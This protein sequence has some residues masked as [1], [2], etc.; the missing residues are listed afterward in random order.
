MPF[1]LTG[2]TATISLQYGSAVFGPVTVSLE[3]DRLI[4]PT[5]IV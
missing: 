3:F 2:S 4:W 1:E 5:L